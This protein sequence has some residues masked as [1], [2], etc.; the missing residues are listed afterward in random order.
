MKGVRS[1]QELDICVKRAKNDHLDIALQ[2]T[3]TFQFIL[4]HEHYN[5]DVLLGIYK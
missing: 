3:V 2:Y 4:L 1:C 5:T